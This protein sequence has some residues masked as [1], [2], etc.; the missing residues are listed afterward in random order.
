MGM[1]SG[2]QAPVAQRPD[3]FIQWISHYL[4]VSIFAKISLF[5][6]VQANI[7]T[8]SLQLDNV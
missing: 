1:D 7:H 8:L 5:P 6:C 3:N 2:N 4:T